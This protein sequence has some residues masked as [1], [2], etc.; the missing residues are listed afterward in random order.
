ML[1]SQLTC[2][3][4]LGYLCICTDCPWKINVGAYLGSGLGSLASI[5]YANQLSKIESCVLDP[6]P[7]GISRKAAAG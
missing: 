6:K 1:K 4:G 7:L 5:P 3:D 2:G